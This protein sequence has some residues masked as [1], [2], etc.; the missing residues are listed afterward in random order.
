M[1]HFT[2]LDEALTVDPREV[3]SLSCNF[4]DDGALTPDLGRLTALT[5]LELWECAPTLVVP[6]EAAR[7]R[8]LTKL[9]LHADKP[10]GTTLPLAFSSLR[11]KDLSVP[12]VPVAELGRF[13]ALERLE[14]RSGGMLAKLSPARFP[15]LRALVLDHVSAADLRAV[16]RFTGLEELSL[17]GPRLKTLP[18]GLTRLTRL[19]S[20]ALTS[21]KMSALPRVVPELGWLE[22]LE[23]HARLPALPETLARLTRL[24]R[25]DLRGAL[26]GGC[27]DRSAKL[28]N[29]NPLPPVLEALKA[30]EEL[31]LDACGVFDVAGLAQLRALRVLSLDY[32]Y[33]PTCDGLGKLRRLESLNL[34][35]GFRLESLDGLARLHALTHLGLGEVPV[36][37]LAVLAQLPLLTSLDLGDTRVRDLSPV[38]EHEA[39]ETLKGDDELVAR[40]Q[41]ERDLA[42]LPSGEELNAALGR[43]DL[44]GVELALG[45]LAR[46]VAAASTPGASALTT[47]L[48]VPTPRGPGPHAVE[49]LDA[50]LRRHLP[51][52]SDDALVAVFEAC[53]QRAD[54]DFAAALVA[55]DEL[56]RRRA[57]TAQ[58][59]LIARFTAACEASGGHRPRTATVRD[60]LV[61]RSF[62]GL[63]G[64]PVAALLDWASVASLDPHVGDGYAQ[65][66]KPAFA[67]ATT[68]QAQRDLVAKLKKYLVK[69]HASAPLATW[70]ALF[71][72]LAAAA[73]ATLQPTVRAV[74][75]NWEEGHRV[76]EDLKSLDVTRVTRALG[77]LKEDTE[78]SSEGRRRLREALALEGLGFEA[79]AQYLPVEAARDDVLGEL[80]TRLVALDLEGL[81]RVLPRLPRA[82]KLRQR[83]AKALREVSPP[84]GQRKPTPAEVRRRLQ[85]AAQGL[86]GVATKQDPLR[87]LGQEISESLQFHAERLLK[88]LKTTEGLVPLPKGYDLADDIVSLAGEGDYASVVA[89]AS[90][91]HRFKLSNRTLE[92]ALAQGIG[93]GSL[94]RKWGAVAELLKR[95]PRRVTWNI[96]AYNLACYHAVRENRAEL[97]AWVKRAR[98]LGKPRGQFLED[99][100][101]APYLE[102]VGFQQALGK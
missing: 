30:L 34:S 84:E 13:K 49:P 46:R 20:L 80:L 52:L 14:L 18:A 97:L 22:E 85:V 60:V 26:N 92:R 90:Q 99:A 70:S 88:R 25:L 57:T 98:A 32:H 74:L 76:E 37:S 81:E 69:E 33:L 38:F 101:F 71:E 9:C 39:L 40:F 45:Q 79:L 53:F 11:V 94:T 10:R 19:R 63:E 35:N 55:T 82:P 4:R 3:T 24:R 96:L 12:L 16:C 54:D 67:R 44:A 78:L 64:G 27:A 51:A 21:E 65:L 77:S 93:A 2:S 5:E 48:G 68:R 6:R 7:L 36:K 91:L 50:V 1:A 31:N 56:V 23:V 8:A 62:L 100:D 61:E 66:F 58:G 89:W 87:E 41:R 102:D 83:V 72:R 29:L 75:T 73:P 17:S 95:V 28:E 59:K 42:T 47:E 43:P 15:R 86:L